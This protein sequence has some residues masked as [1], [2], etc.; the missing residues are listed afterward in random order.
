MNSLTV[1]VAMVHFIDLLYII[2]GERVATHWFIRI[3]RRA[4][5]AL[6]FGRGERD[7]TEMH[8]GSVI[9]RCLLKSEVVLRMPF[10]ILCLTW[11]NIIFYSIV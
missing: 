1:H 10:E 6:P 5:R 4:E 8:Y 3:E 9:I 11:E 2:L 7:C